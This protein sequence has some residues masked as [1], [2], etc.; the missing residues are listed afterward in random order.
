MKEPWFNGTYMAQTCPRA[1]FP[2]GQMGIPRRPALNSCTPMAWLPEAG[3]GLGGTG[4]R[5]P[6]QSQDADGPEGDWPWLG[7]I[8]G[9]GN[10]PSGG[11]D[12]CS[13]P[14]SPP[15]AHGSA[16]RP[17]LD[18]WNR[19]RQRA[20]GRDN[21]LLSIFRCRGRAWPGLGAGAPARRCQAPRG[22]RTMLA[23]MERRHFKAFCSR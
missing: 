9:S 5:E 21:N 14:L 4:R 16:P 6:G 3:P 18:I 10:D 20:A 11:S 1:Q 22:Q 12:P 17:S 2:G 19:G 15:P 8:A 23:V 13:R 7:G